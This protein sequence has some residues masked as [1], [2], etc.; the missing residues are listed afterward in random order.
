MRLLELLIG[1]ILLL[2]M[3]IKAIKGS[4]YNDYVKDLDDSDFPLKEIYCI[5]FAWNNGK[6]LKLRGKFKRTLMK[7]AKL[8]YDEKYAEYYA[9]VIWAQTLSFVHLC[10]C[11]GCIV[12]GVFDFGFFAFVGVVFGGVSAYY[13][14][15]RMKEKLETR[16]T[17]CVVELPEIVSTMAL[18]INSGMILK[19]TWET[20]AYNKEGTIYTLMKQ[21]SVDMQNGVS[22][23]DAI[24]KFGIKSDSPEV[25]KFTGA[26]IQGIE[27][28]SQELSI[29]LSKQSSE[30]WNLKKQVMLQKGEAAAS[31]LLMPIAL[32]FVGILITIISAAVGMLL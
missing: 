22:E 3:F 28:G 18:L 15:T 25:K 19:E 24:H 1:S 13:F 9:T 21:A 31:K 10:V 6:L 4:R 8:L 2:L 17:E 23:V 12:G 26:L 32:I 20:I 5:G 16:K 11:A 27:K 14:I 29:F 7:Q 30:M